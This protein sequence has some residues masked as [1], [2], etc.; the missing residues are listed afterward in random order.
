MLPLMVIFSS[1]TGV[2]LPMFPAAVSS[3]RGLPSLVFN[4]FVLLNVMMVLLF[5]I[6]A[7]MG[8][9][10]WCAMCFMPYVLCR[11]RRARRS[12]MGAFSL[13]CT[14]CGLPLSL[15]TAKSQ[16]GVVA[17]IRRWES[18]KCGHDGRSMLDSCT[19]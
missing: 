10:P 6:F 14:S 2:K 3:R 7:A 11:A 13:G 8:V 16:C 18:L 5:V 17:A 12:P 4:S 1:S 15:D 9:G 19:K